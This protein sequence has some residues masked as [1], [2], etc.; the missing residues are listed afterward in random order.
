MPWLLYPHGQSP[1]YPWDKR[2]GKPQSQSEHGGKE[3]NPFIYPT[4]N[5]TPDVRPIA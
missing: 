1:Q 2:L 4:R 5:Q 3:K